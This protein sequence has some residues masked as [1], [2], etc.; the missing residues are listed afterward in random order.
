MTRGRPHPMIDP[1]PRIEAIGQAA[2]DPA[3]AVLLLDVVLGFAAAP[4][5]AGDLAPA[6]CAALK[7]RADLAV[8]A[9]VIGTEDD[10]Q[11]RSRQEAILRE[12]GAVVYPTS[13]RA[14]A[15]AAGVVS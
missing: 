12:A 14:C 11:V 4:N 6:I 9:S 15:A 10:P 2:A 13:A 8:I 1:R 3:V 5:P 7:A